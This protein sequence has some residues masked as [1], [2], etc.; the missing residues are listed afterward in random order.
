[1]TSCLLRL[2]TKTPS[3]CSLHLSII[4]TWN[5]TRWISRQRFSTAILEKQSTLL[6]LKAAASH[7]NMVLLLRK[8][9]YGLRQS[10]RNFNKAFDKW[11]REERFRAT[12]ADPC[13]YTRRTG[14][15][16][17]MLSLHVD[18][19]LIPC[20][21]RFALDDFKHSLNKKFECSDSGATGYF[22]GFS[23]HRN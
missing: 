4:S 9:L 3:V 17:I 12:I 5:A 11:L 6:R 10:P 14:S 21:N 22:L 2:H 8:S 18:D 15:T 13:I 19:Q 1:L 20:N 7:P 16:F 23:I